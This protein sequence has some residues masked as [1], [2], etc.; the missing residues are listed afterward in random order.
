MRASPGQMPAVPLVPIPRASGTRLQEGELLT[1][2]SC[3]VPMA[4]QVSRSSSSH[5]WQKKDPGPMKRN[6]GAPMGFAGA[7]RFLTALLALF[8]PGLLGKA[9]PSSVM[10][11]RFEQEAVWD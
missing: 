5:V 7:W 4:T 11:Q 8:S 3:C 10:A 2:T 1:R 6:P 9:A